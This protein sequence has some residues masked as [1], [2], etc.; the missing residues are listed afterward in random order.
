TSI[1]KIISYQKEVGE[2]RNIEEFR[3]VAN[4]SLDEVN[5]IK[6]ELSFQPSFTFPT[7]PL[8]PKDSFNFSIK[9]SGLDSYEGYKLDV[10]Y[11]FYESG[12]KKLTRGKKSIEIK[13]GVG[14][15]TSGKIDVNLNIFGFFPD[16]PTFKIVIISPRKNEIFNAQLPA[17]EGGELSIELTDYSE[18]DLDYKIKIAKPDADGDKI[19]TYKDFK[20]VVNTQVNQGTSRSS[21]NKEFLILPDFE[22]DIDVPDADSIEF[23][24]LQIVTAKGEIINSQTIDGGNVQVWEKLSLTDGSPLWDNGNRTLNIVLPAPIQLTPNVFLKEK[25]EKGLDIW[26]DH[27]LVMR[28]DIL[29]RE[30][31]EFKARI[32]EEYEIFTDVADA[33]KRGKAEVKLEYYGVVEFIELE[34]KSPRGEIIGRGKKSPQEIIDAGNVVE[35]EVPPRRIEEIIDLKIFPDR[36]KKSVGRVIDFYGRKKFEDAQIIIYAADKPINEDDELE[37][38]PILTSTTET[39]GYFVIT[40][41]DRFYEAAYAVIGVEGQNIENLKIPIRLELD[42]IIEKVVEGEGEERIIKERVVKEKFF[43]AKFILVIDPSLANDGEDDCD[44]GDCKE[45]DFH[46]QR[47]VLEEFSYYSIVRTTEPQI[48]GYTLLEGGKMDVGSFIDLVEDLD[49]EADKLP[50]NVESLEIEK[51]ILLKYVNNRKGLTVQSLNKAISESKALKLKEKIKPKRQIRAIGRN[52]LDANNPIDWDEDPTIYQATSLAHGHILHFKQE[53]INDGFSLGDL[54]YSLP[55]A[56]GQKKQIVVFDWERREAASGSEILDYREGLYNSLGRDRDINEIVAGTVGEQSAGGS[57]ARTSSKSEAGGAAGGLGFALGPVVIG[58]GGAKGW[59]SGSSSASSN[60]WQKSSR[61]STLSSLQQLRDRTTQSANATRSQRSTVIQTASQGERFSVETE[62]VANYNHCHALTIEYFEVLRHFQIQS[63]LSDVQE[64]LFVPLEMS[65]FDPKKALRWREILSMFLLNDPYSRRLETRRLIRGISNPL[66]RG[67]DAIERR[68][69]QY[70][71]SNLPTGIYADESINYVEGTLYL[72]FQLTRPLDKVDDEGNEV[73]DAPRWGFLRWILPSR[74][75]EAMRDRYIREE[76][77]RRDIVFQ[78]SV[79]P[80]IA[81]AFV[82]H[83]KIEAILINGN[84][85]DLE[86]DATLLSRYQDNRNL[87]VSLR[88]ADTNF[89]GLRRSD[90]RFIRISTDIIGDNGDFVDPS[91]LL[92]EDSR[93]IVSSGFMSYKTDHLSSYLFRNSRINNDLT[94]QDNVQIYTPLNQIEERNPRREDEELAEALIDHLND[95]LEYYHGVIW[96]RMN[97][98]RRFMFLD[99]IQVVDYSESDIYPEGVVRSVASVVENRVIGIEGNCLIMPVA[100]GFRLD[101]NTRGQ[102]IDL[103]EL[104]KPPTPIEPMNVSIPTKGVFAEA[105]MGKCN[106]CERKEEDRFWRW[107]ESPI[108]DSP[109]DI[110]PISTDSRR[111]QPLDTRPTELPNSVIN[112]QNAP[113]AP[114]PTG[115]SALSQ[116]LSNPNFENIT[117]LDGNQR[118]ALEGL[119][120]SFNTTTA[121]GDMATQLASEGMFLSSQLEAIRKAKENND[122]DEPTARDL[123]QRSINRSIDY[124]GGGGNSGISQG[125]SQIRQLNDMVQ[126]GELPPE[127]GQDLTNRVVDNISRSDSALIENPAIQDR[128]KG[129]DSLEYSSGGDSISLSSGDLADSTSDNSL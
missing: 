45:L 30:T 86:I 114:N 48:R 95:N 35:I 97:S 40:T 83:L 124:G 7:R 8:L 77:S 28:Y 10:T 128:I 69:S 54:L 37:Y 60:A 103:L 16:N 3:K 46:K 71:N 126:R 19:F 38:H 111:S 98:R 102:E 123:T 62:T 31:L 32:E 34:V 49:T 87:E 6:G 73:I 41:P 2:I 5:T 112:I 64:C 12:V 119:L 88:M 13:K 82:Q 96:M 66:M 18:K 51:S 50:P 57:T 104:Y 63:R 125:L 76:I 9:L 99:G 33:Q 26:A 90:I 109:T 129:G 56:P 89:N 21:Y 79:A 106:S 75:R 127:V 17:V 78:R 1:E 4:L 121:F 39:G 59:S 93:V 117:G 14:A 42:N 67:F 118:N 53:W 27:K 116:L 20:I 29:D 11:F 120:A 15:A 101:P 110:Q 94:G 72:R 100:S 44:C 91:E 65:T 122:I 36:P 58:G 47:K 25:L 43:P 22:V 108:P 61:S 84:P 115:L 68:E 81:E 85:I 105:V 74:T 113:A 80:E 24:S 107:E 55:L 23:V 70:E 92:P 52:I